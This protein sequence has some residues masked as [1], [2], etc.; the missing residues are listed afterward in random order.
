MT[1][2]QKFFDIVV[3]GAGPAGSMAALS[4]KQAAPDLSVAFID[5][6]TCVKPRIGEALLTGTIMTLADAGLAE[7]LLR[8]GFHHKIGA[9]Y[10]WGQT[11]EPWYVDYPPSSDPYPAGFTHASGRYA[12]HVHRPLFDSFLRRHAIKAG[13][14]AIQ[15]RVEKVVFAETGRA[16]H[17]ELANGERVRFRHLID[18]TGQAALLGNAAGMRKSVGERRVARYGYTHAICWEEAH[19]NGFHFNRT[20]IVS[21]KNGWL[22]VIHLGAAG[23]DL[24][25]VGVV[26]SPEVASSLTPGNITDAFPDLARFGLDLGL[27]DCR[28]ADGTTTTRLVAHSDYGFVCENLHGPNWALA[29]DAAMFIDPILSQGV[30]LAVHYGR[31]RGIA[32]AA[33]IQ[34]DETSQ[35]RVSA[36]Y[37]NEGAILHKIVGEWYAN[38]KSVSG[39]KNLAKQSLHGAVDDGDEAFRHV[40]NLENIRNEYDPFSSEMRDHVRDRL[41]IGN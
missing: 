22:W 17:L 34:G 32:A 19:A 41:G 23:G 2:H 14:E 16:L 26:C 31:L 20:N 9:A 33:A 36:H 21:S 28:T 35:E 6:F 27:L 25:S 30:T 40:T 12:A 38:N 11:R 5:D 1:R 4:A 8:E 24:T 3:I 7:P 10:V 18:A 15:G 29:G 37:R 39:W 13:A